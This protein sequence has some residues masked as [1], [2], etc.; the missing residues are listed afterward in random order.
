MGTQ[1]SSWE[2]KLGNTSKIMPNEVRFPLNKNG[3]L[4]LPFRFAFSS[5]TTEA[6]I[7]LTIFFFHFDLQEPHSPI[8]TSP[9][10]SLE[11]MAGL[12]FVPTVP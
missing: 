8:S 1:T 9:L 3:V 5:W 12:Y 4:L 2:R 10:T 11:Y 6:V 7:M